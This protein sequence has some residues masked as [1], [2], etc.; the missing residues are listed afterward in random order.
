MTACT[1]CSC[2][3]AHGGGRARRILG[4]VA[5]AALIAAGVWPDAARDQISQLQRRL[6]LWRPALVAMVADAG[7]RVA[8]R[9][10]D[11]VRERALKVVVV[12]G[13]VQTALAAAAPEVR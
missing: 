12:D 3:H 6:E 1:H 8:H 7:Q 4:C 13:P 11:E 5:A 2:G 10:A 9:T